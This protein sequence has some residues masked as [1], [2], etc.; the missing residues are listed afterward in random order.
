MS[1]NLN[2]V[3]DA[4][5]LPSLGGAAINLLKFCD[6]DEMFEVFKMPFSDERYTYATDRICIIR[7][8]KVEMFADFSGSDAVMKR[9]RDTFDSIGSC[10]WQ[11]IPE[12]D[13]PGG[14]NR[15][16]VE[17]TWLSWR[18][19]DLLKAEL[20]CVELAFNDDPKGVI[21]VRFHGGVG[22]IMPMKAPE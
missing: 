8:D 17:N 10:S 5:P 13:T 11:A 2:A 22:A 1:V 6:E 19:L 16:A 4:L 20:P 3:P 18:H 9:V 21:Y 14:Y 7:V 12:Y 15:V